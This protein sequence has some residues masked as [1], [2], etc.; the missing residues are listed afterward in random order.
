MTRHRVIQ[1]ATG[2]MGRTCLQAV[3]D[4]PRLAAARERTTAKS[5]AETEAALFLV[6]Q[7]GKLLK[8]GGARF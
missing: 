7:T 5:S 1:W 3:I 6:K 4:H 8:R 2:A